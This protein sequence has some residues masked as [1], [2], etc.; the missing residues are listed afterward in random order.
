[1]KQLVALIIAFAPLFS[2]T[3]A[4]FYRDNPPPYRFMGS[5]QGNVG[6]CQAE[7]EVAAL[8]SVFWEMGRSVKLSSFHRHALNWED[9]DLNSP[10][11]VDADLKLHYTKEDREV[12]SNLGGVIPYYMLPDVTFGFDPNKTGVRVGISKIVVT[13]PNYKAFAVKNDHFTF[14]PNWA[15]TRSV[16]HLKQAVESNSAVMLT[17]Q[18]NILM[19]YA[20]DHTTG[21]LK[22]GINL[23]DYAKLDSSHA[24]SVIGYDDSLYSDYGFSRAGALIIKNSWN[25]KDRIEETLNPAYQLPTEEFNK[26]RGKISQVTNLPGYYAIPYALIDMIVANKKSVGFK[27]VSMDFQGFADQH[28]ALLNNYEVVAAPFVCGPPLSD[29]SHVRNL[30]RENVML[31]GEIMNR[32]MFKQSVGQDYSA[33]SDEVMEMMRVQMEFAT[34]YYGYRPD[35]FSY[36]FLS[37][38]KTTNVDRVADFYQGKFNDY[39]C[40]GGTTDFNDPDHIYP[41]INHYNDSRFNKALGEFSVDVFSLINW[42][43]LVQSLYNTEIDGHV[44]VQPES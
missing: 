41:N 26:M 14:L 19:G 17:F 16:D 42:W 39:Y 25:S 22:K 37:Q 34:G 6:S 10:E 8:E 35:K 4:E 40:F 36:A 27:M 18:P 9:E 5:D 20:Y 33:E 2:A 11:N 13:D 28:D 29:V 1:M 43:V 21:L 24:V 32:A 23:E 7:A 44:D 30:A 31:F 3:A 38:N 12:L 15:N